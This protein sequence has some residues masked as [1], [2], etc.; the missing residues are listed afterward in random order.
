M[1]EWCKKDVPLQ[2]HDFMLEGT[3]YS[4]FTMVQGIFLPNKKICSL[5]FF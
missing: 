5:I 2:P 1:D 3:N 4:H